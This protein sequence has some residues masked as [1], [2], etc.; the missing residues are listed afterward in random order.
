MYNGIYEKSKFPFGPIDCWLLLQ[1]YQF[2]TIPD[3]STRFLCLADFSPTFTKSA[4]RRLL[5]LHSINMACIMFFSLNCFCQKDDDQH[6]PSQQHALSKLFVLP[7]EWPNTWSKYACLESR[8]CNPN[9][10]FITALRLISV[11]V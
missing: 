3:C 9:Q 4:S 6:W 1:P 10:R 11:T 7:K 8:K 2:A 5:S